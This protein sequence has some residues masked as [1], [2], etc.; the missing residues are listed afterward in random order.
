MRPVVPGIAFLVPLC[1][2]QP[3]SRTQEI[4][5]ERE[6]KSA[7]LT[8]DTLSKPEAILLAIRDRKIIERLTAGANGFGAQIGNMVTGAGFAIGPLYRREDLLG[9]RLTTSTYVQGATS[10]SYKAETEWIIRPWKNDLL[11]F[12]TGADHRNYNR[13]EFY[14]QGPDSKKTGRSNYRLED[15]N[16][17]GVVGTRAGLFRFAAGTGY[18]WVN[19]GPGTRD[20]VISTDKIYGPLQAPGIDRQTNFLRTTVLGQFD[21]RDSSVGPKS[22][23]NYIFQYTWFNDQVLNR[24]SFRRTDI[25]LRQYVPLFNKTRVLALRARTTLTETDGDN[26]VPFYYQPYL[27]GSDDLRG[28]RAFRFTGPQMV[29]FNAEY[30]W[31]IFSGLDGAVFWD[32]GK[33]TSRRGLV[34]FSNLESTVGFGLRFNVRNATFLR[35]DAGFSHEG[36]QF[37][38]KFND[39]YLPRAFG[40]SLRQPAY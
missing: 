18:S 23:G 17:D 9:G 10:L 20:D 25:D 14:G 39:P 4:E 26:V 21:Y 28:Y 31:E 12:Y 34:N 30:R 1:F 37:W 7:H 6:A 33:V 19:V 3:P 32:G 35:F 22:G 2:A 27:G 36:F 24:F 11:Q 15:T 16:W 5:S 38:F 40:V 29:N 13:M 8:P